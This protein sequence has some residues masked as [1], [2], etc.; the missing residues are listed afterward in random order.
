MI[1][2]VF[3]ELR[4]RGDAW[5]WF[6]TAMRH[7]D[8]YHACSLAG[9]FQQRHGFD[10]PIRLVVNTFPA[11]SVAGI[12]DHRIA[13]IDVAPHLNPTADEWR[14][15][16]RR[17]EL[18]AF[19]PNTPLILHPHRNPATSELNEFIASNG[20]V[21]GQLYKNT[22]H[23]P[24]D[25]EPEAP[26]A[27]PYRTARA[28][29]LLSANELRLGR[30]MILFPYAQSF[31]VT[32]TA[33]F[34][35]LA[36]K[37]SSEGWDVATSV[38]PGEA[39]IPNTKPVFIPFEILLEVVQEAGWVVAVR[40]GICDITAT[41][42]CIKSFIFRHKV[43]LPIWGIDALDLARDAQQLVVPFQLV[44]P[45][46]FSE[47]I[48]KGKGEAP[49][50]A[51]RTLSDL[52]TDDREDDTVTLDFASLTRNRVS[53]PPRAMRR[54]G[55][56]ER[57]VNVP[58]R[59]HPRFESHIESLIDELGRR[60]SKDARFY[61]CR[62]AVRG[63]DF[64][65]EVDF[66]SLKSGRYAAS[67]KWHTIV[68]TDKGGLAARLKLT[69]QRRLLERSCLGLGHVQ[70]IGAAF[71][72]QPHLDLV[73]GD[74]PIDIGGLQ[75]LKGWSDLEAWGIWS[76]GDESVLKFTIAEPPTSVVTLSLQAKVLVTQADG[77]LKLESFVNGR[78]VTSLRAREH[79]FVELN[80]G[81]TPDLLA[82]RTGYVQFCHAGAR[83]PAQLG[84]A[85]DPRRIAFGLIS[86]TLH[87]GLGGSRSSF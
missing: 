14:E 78:H 41:A 22:L 36:E 7:G 13:S 76:E 30:S 35:R 8:M 25:V 64:F 28:R 84:P 74:R 38:A 65:E 3:D 48:F 59:F 32:A 62:D 51:R 42:R 16:L 40:S 85:Q 79:A 24:S 75:L 5:L 50:I 27:R 80:V 34:E 54:S 73:N 83:S 60:P 19:G 72:T 1:D 9:A 31:P 6:G 57:I 45:R 10:L 77:E 33:H 23:L 81:I 4:T 82:S 61:T 63:L 46:A 86:A 49:T 68:A 58:R 12:F 66:S 20:L 67:D 47:Q 87:H 70:S 26:P 29:E 43:E 53:T 52:V 17:R 69:A 18:P 39:P 56:L 2:E 11:E 15:F 21:W 71:G 44:T 37:A 55:R